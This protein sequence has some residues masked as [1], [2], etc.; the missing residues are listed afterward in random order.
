MK[1]LHTIAQSG[2]RAYS[3]VAGDQTFDGMP[4]PTWEAI[5]G[6]RHACWE[7]AVTH[8]AGMSD[9]VKGVEYLAEQAWEAYSEQ[10]NGLSYNSQTLPV[11]SALPS[12]RQAAWQAAATQILAELAT[13]Q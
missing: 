11:W 13:V 6:D 4:L 12:D 3:K 7:A 10:A 2:Y 1:Q 8:I 9:L 5:G